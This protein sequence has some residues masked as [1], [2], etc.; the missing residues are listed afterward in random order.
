[1]SGYGSAVAAWMTVPFTSITCPRECLGYGQTNKP[2]K[3]DTTGI[4][5]PASGAMAH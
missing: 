1:M 4:D 3:H 2:M 5:H